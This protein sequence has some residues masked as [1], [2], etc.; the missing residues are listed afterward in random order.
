MG[1]LGRS[2]APLM[3]VSKLGCRSLLAGV[4]G[5]RPFTRREQV[6]PP[7]AAPKATRARSYIN[8][9][10]RY[11]PA[12]CAAIAF[13]S[14]NDEKRKLVCRNQY[15]RIPGSISSAHALIPPVMLLTA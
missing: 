1:M 15:F 13:C 7:P 14:Q 4:V 12:K 9:V 10:H 5:I 3:N 11:V 6:Y 8:P 2:F